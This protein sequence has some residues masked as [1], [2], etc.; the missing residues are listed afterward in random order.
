VEKIDFGVLG[1]KI[2]DQISFCQTGE[3]FVVASGNGT[4]GNG[5][6]LVLAPMFFPEGPC[7]LALLTKRLLGGAPAL[8]V[9]AL[10]K[11]QD[12]FLNHLPIGSPRK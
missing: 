5:G 12:L 11:W 6:T 7:S 3:E 4:P 9:L 1:L 2:G 8:D 10:W